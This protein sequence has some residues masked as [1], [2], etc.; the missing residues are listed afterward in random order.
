MTSWDQAS[1][2]RL[3]IS[4]KVAEGGNQSRNE[5]NVNSGVNGRHHER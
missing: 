1:P 4:L 5:S 3:G 2:A